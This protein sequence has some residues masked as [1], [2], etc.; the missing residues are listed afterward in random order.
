MY[1]EIIKIHT[2]KDYFKSLTFYTTIL[3]WNIVFQN[4]FLYYLCA[5]TIISRLSLVCK[6][7]LQNK[8]FFTGT[9]R[10]AKGTK[11]LIFGATRSFWSRKYPAV[12]ANKLILKNSFLIILNLI[13]FK[14]HGMVR[15][16]FASRFVFFEIRSL[17]DLRI[18]GGTR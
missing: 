10:F 5:Y 17:Q 7:L 9:Q 6:R 16:L 1:L 12:I 3:Q 2:F 8:V 11:I 15:G 18:K 13:L 14:T 4:K